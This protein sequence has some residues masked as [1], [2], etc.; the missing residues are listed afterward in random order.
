MHKHTAERSLGGKVFTRVHSW[1]PAVTHSQA[2]YLDQIAASDLPR[3]NL[4]QGGFAGARWA[5]QQAHA[6][7][8]HPENCQVSRAGCTQLARNAADSMSC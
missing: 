7:L 4:E 6:T 2:A 8:Q 1:T 5:Q 3:K